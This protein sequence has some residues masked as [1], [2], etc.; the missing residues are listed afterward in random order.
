MAKKPGTSPP[1]PPPERGNPE[2]KGG[3]LERARAFLEERLTP[4]TPQI[5]TRAGGSRRDAAG[6]TQRAGAAQEG[7]AGLRYHDGPGR[8]KRA[9][10]HTQTLH[11]G[12][13][14]AG[15]SAWGPQA[16]DRRVP[17][18]PDAR[19]DDATRF[20]HTA[21]ATTWWP[22][23]GARWGDDARPDG[24]TTGQQLDSDRPV[25]GASR[26]GPC[27]ARH[28]RPH[29]GDRPARRGQSSLCRRGK[30]GCVAYARMAGPPGCR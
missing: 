5:G 16:R 11:A 7:S 19:Q 12:R 4:A 27:Q 17:R 24:A 10:G 14:R 8:A 18:A 29:T 13:H 2:P 15:V 26:P 1:P 20:P 22:R 25:R 23:G 9:P 21:Q 6:R 30:W 28:Q 3:P